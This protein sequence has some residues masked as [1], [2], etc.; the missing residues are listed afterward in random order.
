MW[1]NLIIT[2]GVAKKA[3]LR[4]AKD[5]LSGVDDQTVIRQ[6]LKELLMVLLDG[7]AGNKDII[8]VNK[9]E[10]E[11]TV[12]TVHKLLK[13]LFDIPEGERHAT[14]FKKA[15]GCYDVTSE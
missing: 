7:T 5:T 12:H 13:G 1:A 6:T 10:V 2:D 14:E 11:A 15:E 4:F 9:D 3:Q 8:L